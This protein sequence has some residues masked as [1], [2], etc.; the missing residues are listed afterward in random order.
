[1]IARLLIL[2][3]KLVYF[4]PSFKW[5]LWKFLATLIFSCFSANPILNTWFLSLMRC[6]ICHIWCQTNRLVSG[7]K[8]WAGGA[9]RISC[10]AWR[11]RSI[12]RIS[13]AS[14]GPTRP[15]RP[16]VGSSSGSAGGPAISRNL[17]T[18]GPWMDGWK[19]LLCH[20]Q[21][22]R[23]LGLDCG[24]GWCVLKFQSHDKCAG[25]LVRQ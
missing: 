14:C 15:G 3:A 16:P 19:V 25:C 2:N 8:L 17:S 10:W 24:L 18:S 12:N 4:C 9:W 7:I 11:I 23:Q 20:R 13:L 22:C 6:H 5:I 1:M 21:N